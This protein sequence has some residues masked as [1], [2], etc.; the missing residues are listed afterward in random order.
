[1]ARLTLELDSK[2]ERIINEYAL[3]WNCSKA[4][5]VRTLVYDG[6]LHNAQQS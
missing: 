6:I 3:K 2:L 1:M 5:V 4:M